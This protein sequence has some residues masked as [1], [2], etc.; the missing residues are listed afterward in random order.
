METEIEKFL[1]QFRPYIREHGGDVILDQL[2][3]ETVT[4]RV[5]GACAHCDLANL[6]YNKLIGGLLHEKWPALKLEIIYQ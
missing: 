2:N 4:L 3:G 1:E 6:T 5:S